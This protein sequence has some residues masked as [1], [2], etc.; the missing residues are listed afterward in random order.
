MAAVIIK[1]PTKPVG[2]ADARVPAGDSAKSAI[3]GYK[4]TDIDALALRWKL[5]DLVCS[6]AITRNDCVGQIHQIAGFVAPHIKC[7]SLSFLGNRG[8]DERFGRIVDV[9]QIPT[10]LAAPD[11]ENLS[12]YHPAQ[13]DA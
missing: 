7:Q 2:E 1:R 4:I 12:L 13:P 9:K 10:L 5:P 11:L 3:V 8:I 6:A